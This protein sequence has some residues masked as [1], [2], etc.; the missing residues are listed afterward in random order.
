MAL[1]AKNPTLEQVDQD[2]NPVDTIYIVQGEMNKLAMGVAGY[3]NVCAVPSGELHRH[4][5]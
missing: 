4:A 5:A 3:L 1:L 2:P